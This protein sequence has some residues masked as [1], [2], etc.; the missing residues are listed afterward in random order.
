[1]AGAS[2]SGGPPVPASVSSEDAMK[3]PSVSGNYSLGPGNFPCRLGHATPQIR[4][5]T[6]LD[7]WHARCLGTTRLM[8]LHSMRMASP[9]LLAV[10][11]LARDAAAQTAAPAVS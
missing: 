10:G 6:K 1:M 9:L 11:L 7:G 4:A 3:P 5:M 2:E 8:T